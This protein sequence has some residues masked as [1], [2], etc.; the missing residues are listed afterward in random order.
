MTWGNKYA[1]AS[2]VSGYSALQP[3]TAAA[4]TALFVA[5]HVVPS[6]AAQ[7]DDDDGACLTPAGVQD[8]GALGVF[9]GLYLIVTSEPPSEPPSAPSDGA[10]LLIQAEET[11]GPFGNGERRGE[12]DT[13]APIRGL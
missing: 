2:L 5:A 3:V 7:G 9:A 10:A 8:L 11:V 1:S 13:P 12:A 4:L 6:C